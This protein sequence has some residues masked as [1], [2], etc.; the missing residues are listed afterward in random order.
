[1]PVKATQVPTI[2][3][4]L[5]GMAICGSHYNWLQRQTITWLESLW[6]CVCQVSNRLSN[7]YWAIYNTLV[8]WFHDLVNF[9]WETLICCRGP[10]SLNF[11]DGNFQRAKT[12]RTKCVN[13]FRDKKSVRKFFLWQKRCINSFC[14]KKSVYRLFLQQNKCAQIIFATKSLR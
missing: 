11:P 3:P 8:P 10:K 13:R 14:D 12:F 4:G 2:R 5:E 9:K 1:M 7:N 6:S